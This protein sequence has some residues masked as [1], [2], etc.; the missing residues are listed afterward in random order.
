MAVSVRRPSRLST[1]VMPLLAVV[2][3]AAVGLVT[4]VRP[5]FWD[6]LGLAL[7]SYAAWRVNP[8]FGIAAAGLSCFIVSFGVNAGGDRETHR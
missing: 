2:Q 1:L 5:A 4:A 8:T 7:L 6:L 3:T